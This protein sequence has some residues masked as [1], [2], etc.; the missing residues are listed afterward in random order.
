[1][2]SF[3][4]ES[5]DGET[6]ACSFIK[7]SR[8]SPISFQGLTDASV[9][10]FAFWPYQDRLLSLTCCFSDFCS[11]YWFLLC[12]VFRKNCWS[13][14]S[15]NFTAFLTLSFE[16]HSYQKCL[17]CR[18]GTRL[19]HSFVDFPRDKEIRAGPPASLPTYMP[20]NWLLSC[21][22]LSYL[23]WRWES[24]LLQWLLGR[25]RDENDTLLSV[26][27]KCCVWG[28]ASIDSSHMHSCLHCLCYS[29]AW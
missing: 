18:A 2:S 16:L 23:P 24:L 20:Y 13:T 5:C 21:Y 27:S 4:S 25:H 17:P 8:Y 29:V 14:C 3:Y 26:T 15:L 11:P 10:W 28:L 1:M 12:A 9:S 6:L 7:L 22:F 19:W